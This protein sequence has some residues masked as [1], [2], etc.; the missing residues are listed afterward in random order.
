[1]IEYDEL[2]IY[3]GCDI[4]ITS[5][6]I[7]TQPTLNQIVEFGEKRYFN[8]VHTLT[9]V[10]A[11]MK[12]QLWEYQIDYTM[13]DDYDLFVQFISQLV[14]SKKKIYKELID[15]PEKYEKQLSSFSQQELDDMLINPLQLV[16]KDI[17]LAD[18]TLMKQKLH[19]N[20]EQ[21][22][23]YNIERDITIDRFIYTQIMDVVRKIHGF[24]RNSEIPANEQTKMDLIE[25]ARD[26]AMLANSKP[27]KS[28]LKSLVSTLS[29]KCGQCGDERIWNMGINRFFY[30]IKRVSKIQDAELLLKGAYSGFGSLKGIDKTR[31]DMFGDI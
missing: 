16:L 17:D 20:N 4:S 27:Y 18:F 13:I 26:E 6:I 21:I 15:N 5:K 8:A 30:D 29:V 7:V 12:W 19:E 25:D 2:K 11:D 9:S 22:I 1:M 14:S 24:K 31:L 3:R 23:L 28:V 10:G